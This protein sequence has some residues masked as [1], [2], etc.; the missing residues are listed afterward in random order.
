M[1][2]KPTHYIT[3]FVQHHNVIDSTDSEIYLSILLLLK[4]MN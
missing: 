3:D 1:M 4:L 2:T